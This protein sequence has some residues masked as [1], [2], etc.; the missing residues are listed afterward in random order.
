MLNSAVKFTNSHLY[1][2][3]VYILR[4]RCCHSPHISPVLI[5]RFTAK[6]APR[7]VSYFKM[8]IRKI[9]I[10]FLILPFCDFLRECILGVSIHF[11]LFK[12]FYICIN[13]FSPNFTIKGLELRIALPP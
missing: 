11:L 7:C 1:K 4:L 8:V 13:L 5:E 3:G 10:G 6:F 2:K 12:L 9:F